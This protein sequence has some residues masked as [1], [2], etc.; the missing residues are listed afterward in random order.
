M[1][2]MAPV[3][4]YLSV[5]SFTSHLSSAFLSVLSIP[6]P[7]PG[8]QTMGFGIY[9]PV[10]ESYP[11][12]ASLYL[13]PSL[14]SLSE[15]SL[16]DLVLR[17]CNSLFLMFLM[18]IP[19]HPGGLFIFPFSCFRASSPSRP[20]CL[21]MLSTCLKT[22]AASSIERFITSQTSHITSFWLILTRVSYQSQSMCRISCSVHLPVL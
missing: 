19:R 6:D 11:L 3:S 7:G 12:R 14:C 15:H 20:L 21:Y 18:C 10:S 17:H 13:K 9:D 5:L 8:S 22:D 16:K 1:F 4:V 2:F